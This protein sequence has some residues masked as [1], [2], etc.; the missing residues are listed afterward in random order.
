MA[1]MTCRKA[2][3]PS[4]L[5]FF[6]LICCWLC[7]QYVF[8]LLAVLAV[9]FACCLLCLLFEAVS[10]PRLNLFDSLYDACCNLRHRNKRPP[11]QWGGGE[12]CEKKKKRK[13][14]TKTQTQTQTQT[15]KKK[16]LC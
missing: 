13:K 3:S 14:K 8:C 6:Q 9:C 10:D 12:G 11:T 2:S 5:L 1:L 16:T 7:Q 15:K 4:E